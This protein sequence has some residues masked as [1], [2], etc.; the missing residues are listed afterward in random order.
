M[1]KTAHFE[2]DY[3]V[4]AA[5]RKKQK[6]EVFC[7]PNKYGYRLNISN[8]SILPIYEAYKKHYNLKGAISDKQR[9]DLENA[10]IR[11]I[12]REYKLM[13]N[14]KLC[15]PIIGWRLEQLIECVR[16]MDIKKAIKAV[17]QSTAQNQ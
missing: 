8:A 14:D 16:V 7:P 6:L 1:S 3:A 5:E 10:I 4:R 12:A 9:I 17:L 11:H 15:E 2:I 13:Y